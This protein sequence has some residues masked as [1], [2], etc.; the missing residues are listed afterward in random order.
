MGT[1]KRFDLSR[2]VKDYDLTCFVETGTYRG[3]SLSFAAQFGFQ[4][5]LSIDILEKFYLEAKDTFANDPRVKVFLGDTSTDL[6]R[7]LQ[8]ASQ[9]DKCLFWLDAHLPSHYGDEYSTED[10]DNTRIPLER[11]LMQ[12]KESRDYSKDYFIMDDLRIYEDGPYY[13]GNWSDQKTMGGNGIQFIIDFFSGTHRLLKDIRDE[14]YI[15]AEP[16]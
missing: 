12:I 11:E 6:G 3:D 10:E 14:G 9:E 7:L 16:V 2:L 5:L 8:D 1:I 15:I 13:A 4:K